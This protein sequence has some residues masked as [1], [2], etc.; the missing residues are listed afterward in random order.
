MTIADDNVD[1]DWIERP[2]RW[3]IT[4]IR[5]FMV[6]FGLVSSVFDYVTFGVLLSDLSARGLVYGWQGCWACRRLS[7]STL[8]AGH[9]QSFGRLSAQLSLRE[10]WAC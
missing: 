1:R 7:Y 8:M 9:F 5:N 3:D 2:H 10:R 6:V 4:F